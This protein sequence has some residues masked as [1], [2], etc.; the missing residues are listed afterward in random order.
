M[1][2]KT[3]RSPRNQLDWKHNILEVLCDLC[4][5]AL[6]AF[7]D[8]RTPCAP[9]RVHGRNRHFA[10]FAALRESTLPAPGPL[11]IRKIIVPIS[12]KFFMN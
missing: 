9:G 11:A 2:A 6:K 7:G 3:Q 4:I 10:G 5:F 8:L 12:D 1:N